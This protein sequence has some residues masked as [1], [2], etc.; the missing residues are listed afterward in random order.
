VAAE[1]MAA[2]CLVNATA[3]GALP[4]TT[5]GYAAL[6]PFEAPAG[7]SAKGFITNALDLLEQSHDTPRQVEQRLRRQI[8][9]AIRCY[10]P[11]TIGRL[12]LDFLAA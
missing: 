3:I 8:D 5:A 4:E 1:A 6:T 11:G 12:W 9:Y 10:S 7:Y 2:G